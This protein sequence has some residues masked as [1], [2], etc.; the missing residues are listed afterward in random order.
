V[1]AAPHIEVRVG[2]RA[3]AL[4]QDAAG[5]V[6]GILAETPE[7]ETWRITAAATLL[8]TGGL[9]GLYAVT[10]TPRELKGE[11]M[12]L[13]ALAGAIIADPEFVQFHPTGL[14][15]VGVLISEAV[16]GEGA[17]LRNAD[18]DQAVTF[19]TRPLV[20]GAVLE[21]LRRAHE[22]SINI[23]KNNYL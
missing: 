12:G 7:G 22:F 16:R 17:Y 20:S 19:T 6:R 15:P 8:S 14:Y 4:L 21:L 11:G 23:N 13:A 5:R 1:L 3:R 10:T 9:G 18:G 2:L